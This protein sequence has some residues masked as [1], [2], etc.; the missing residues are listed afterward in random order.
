MELKNSIIAWKSKFTGKTG[1]GTTRFS[2]N[3]AK[4]ICNDFNKKYLDIEHGFI[5]DSDMT[6]IH[7][8][9]KS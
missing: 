3:Q 8:P 6:G 2:T 7:V 9:V 5:Q 1:R 4:S